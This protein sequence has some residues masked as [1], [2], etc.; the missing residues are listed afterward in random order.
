GLPRHLGQVADQADRGGQPHL[1][2]GVPDRHR[3]GEVVDVLAG[4]EDVDDLAHPGQWAVR[5]Q[6]L[7]RGGE[8]A[9]EEVLHRLDVVPCLALDLGELGDLRRPEGVDDTAQV[10]DVRLPQ[11]GRAGQGAGGGEVDEPGDLDVE[12]GPVQRRLRE[13]VD[14]GCDD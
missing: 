6:R 14:E 4:A 1:A 2:D 5:A 7:R 3:V 12:P 10:G 13:V 8:A 9:L 11:R